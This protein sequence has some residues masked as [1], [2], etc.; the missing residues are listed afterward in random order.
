LDL[1]DYQVGICT[2]P[3]CRGLKFEDPFLHF[4]RYHGMLFKRLQELNI[5]VEDY[6]ALP[7][8]DRNKKPMK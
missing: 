5:P 7:A 1:T 4:S 8:G 6:T 3:E 2:F